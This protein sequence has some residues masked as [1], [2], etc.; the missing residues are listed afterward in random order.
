MI[1]MIITT[2]TILTF[3]AQNT[4]YY[5]DNTRCDFKLETKYNTILT[6]LHIDGKNAN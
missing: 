3:T 1:N 2:I 4:N 6:T 5:S